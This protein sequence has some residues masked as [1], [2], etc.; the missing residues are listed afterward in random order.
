[1]IRVL[2]IGDVM[3]KPGRE[4]VRALLPELKKR[5]RVDWT[6]VNGENAA[7]G[8]GISGRIARDFWRMGC[9]VVTLGDHVWDQKEMETFLPTTDRLLRPQNFPPGTPGTGWTVQ[10]TVGGLK[11]AVVCLL[12][13]VFMKYAVGC[14]FRTLD[15]LLA[16]IRPKTHV[17]LVEIHA[18]TT[19]EKVALGHFADGRVSAI[20]GTH[21]HVQTADERILPGGTAYLTDLG[22][23]GPHDS[24]IGQNKAAIIRRY[25][26]SMPVRFSVASGRV[27]LNGAVIHVDEQT[28]QAHRITRIQC[29]LTNEGS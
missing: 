12:G 24:V 4:A 13:R 1:M 2:W 18:E 3:G 25:W 6:I 11:V 16:D 19:S 23:T 5:Y 27:I 14:P 28:G 7:G 26:T 21:T 15:T 29:P 22:M 10:T 17:I 8:S 20:V 9:D